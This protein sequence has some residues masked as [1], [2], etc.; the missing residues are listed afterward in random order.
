MHTQTHTKTS[1][2]SIFTFGYGN[3]KDYSQFLEY[4]EKNHI[5]CVVDVRQKTTAWTRRWYGQ[6][7]SDVCTEH[8]VDYCS[9]PALGNTSGS[10]HWIPPNREE[11]HLALKRLA[12]KLNSQKI[13]LLCAELDHHRCH[14]TE[15]AEKLK[16]LTGSKIQHCY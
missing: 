10:Q 12:E 13:L 7:I 8:G 14:R 15:V 3:R 9:E 1:E 16:K 2:A 6:Q 4:L 5:D 11:A